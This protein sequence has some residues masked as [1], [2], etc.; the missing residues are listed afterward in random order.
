MSTHATCDKY[1][2]V[3]TLGSGAYSKV[4]L[5]VDPETNQYVALKVLEKNNPALNN[6]MLTLVANEVTMMSKVNHP[7]IVNMVGF[8]EAAT[9]TKKNGDTREVMYIALELCTGGELFEYV[10]YTGR[11]EETLARTYFQQIVEGIEAC[12]KA[13]IAH[14]DMKPE[15]LLFDD[16]FNLKLADFGFSILLAGRDSSGKLNTRLGTESYM[17]PELHLN[18][19]YNGVAVDLFAAGIILFI[20]ISQ[21]P[22]F[23]K[24]NPSQDPFYRLLCMNKHDIFWTQHS[25]HKPGKDSFYSMEFKDLINAMLAFDPTKRPTIEQIKGH[26]WY[27]GDVPTDEEVLASLTERKAKVEEEQ[28]KERQQKL[29]Q[30]QQQQ[31]QY[32][33]V[34]Q[35]VQVAYRSSE[36]EQPR[37]FSQEIQEVLSLERSMGQ[38]FP[39]VKKFTEVITPIE[40]KQAFGQLI[41]FMTEKANEYTVDANTYKVKANFITE[42]DRVE[43]TV[44]LLQCEDAENVCVEFNRKNG[45]IMDFNNI[46]NEFK[47][48][49]AA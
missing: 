9:Y 26:A 32:G 39:C 27:L 4:R 14:R 47:D 10:F 41:E 38:Y 31:Q 43:L 49:L 15:N 45:P 29:L 19:Q 6:K 1:Q 40:H 23:G 28:E 18:Q 44:K 11:F 33:N 48:K 5:A 8:N 24:A 37:E 22:P 20:M 3:K 34:Y 16:G 46:F 21:N 30:K 12:H 35:G 25:K 13:G 36:D 7:N 42:E 2:I 17:A